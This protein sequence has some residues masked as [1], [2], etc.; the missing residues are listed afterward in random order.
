MD[1]NEKRMLNTVPQRIEVILI[2]NF[3]DFKHKLMLWT[4]GEI[5]LQLTSLIFLKR[6]KWTQYIAVLHKWNR[7]YNFKSQSVVFT[8]KINT[9]WIILKKKL[10]TFTT[11][12][13]K[14]HISFYSRNTFIQRKMPSAS[15]K[16]QIL[17]LYW[18]SR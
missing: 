10:I 15:K 1:K 7:Y 11:N 12:H 8:R 5:R 2:G 17:C 6:H 13:N 3:N 9:I 18:T 4:P 16:S 14:M